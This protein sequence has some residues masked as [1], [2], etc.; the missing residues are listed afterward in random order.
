MIVQLDQRAE[1]LLAEC[2][3]APAAGVGDLGQQTANVQ[4]LQQPRHF[5]GLAAALIGVEVLAHKAWRI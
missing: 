2:R 1:H 3:H 4:T 5:A